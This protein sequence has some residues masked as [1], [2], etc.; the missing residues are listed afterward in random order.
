MNEQN[1]NN[2]ENNIQSKPKRKVWNSV[3]IALVA[4]FMVGIVSG[5]SSDGPAE[6][7]AESNEQGQEAEETINQAVETPKEETPKEETPNGEPF[8][9]Q[10]ISG[11]YTCGIDFPEGEYDIIAVS[12]NGT[13]SSSNMLSGGL[14]EIMGTP[15]DEST[16]DT[17][18]NA[19][20][21]KG[22]VL[23][24]SSVTIKISSESAKVSEMQER[25]NPA[26][27]TVSLGSG[28]FV[29]GEDFEPGVYDIVAVSGSGN[30]SAD[31]MF[32]GGLDAVMGTSSNGS[33]E[34]EY[35]NITLFDGAGISISGVNIELVPS[36]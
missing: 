26:T 4:V 36:K 32:G 14:S 5:C 24:I 21:E 25:E 3:A 31:S 33:D 15:A 35:K 7:K 18:N 30:V 28:D 20:F 19:T 34:K 29:A 11:D 1:L 9:A 22:D 10:L 6:K 17:F 16:I 27:E 2:Q 8:E 12:G 23:S 13:V